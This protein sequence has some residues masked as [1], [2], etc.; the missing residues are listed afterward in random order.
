MILAAL[1]F[2]RKVTLTTTVTRVTED[3]L[4]DG[5]MHVLQGKDIPSYVAIFRIHG[6][7][8]FGVRTRLTTFDASAIAAV[9]CGAAPA[10]YDG[11]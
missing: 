6:P 11:A 4:E 1:V 2:I 7:F 10:Q 5:R 8:L 3:D 9:D